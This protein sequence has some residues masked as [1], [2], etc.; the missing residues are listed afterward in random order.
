MSTIYCCICLKN[1]IWLV[2]EP[3]LLAWANFISFLTSQN[4]MRLSTWS[5]SSAKSIIPIL[6]H[7]LLPSSKS[8]SFWWNTEYFVIWNYKVVL[9]YDLATEF[10]W[11]YMPSGHPVFKDHQH[12]HYP[13]WVAP[14]TFQ[15][16]YYL[17]CFYHPI[18]L[19]Y[20]ALHL[21]L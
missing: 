8:S 11:S 4:I 14:A 2:Q 18:W 5:T 13:F 12:K 20:Q 7:A 10:N 3:N 21:N 6:L 15:C 16:A 19:I 1:C 17:D 9:R